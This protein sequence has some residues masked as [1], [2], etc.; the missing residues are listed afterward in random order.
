MNYYSPA[1]S[2]TPKVQTNS[3]RAEFAQTE[4]WGNVVPFDPAE[5]PS[6]P[7][8][9]GA[10]RP[11]DRFAATDGVPPMAGGTQQDMGMQGMQGMQAM[12]PPVAG[13][14]ARVSIVLPPDAPE[15]LTQPIYTPGYLRTQIG[16]L[17]RV[18]FLIGN[19]TTDRVGVLRDVGASFIILESLDL[20]STMLCDLFSIKFVTIIGSTT[21]RGLIASFQ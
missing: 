14:A 10:N 17:M 15:T 19:V 6:S 9:S 4:S 5:I 16:R 20:G 3:Q 18:E 7:F 21:D 12:Q 11:R 8:N 1:T 2:N 13:G